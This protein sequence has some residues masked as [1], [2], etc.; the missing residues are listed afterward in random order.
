MV[1]VDKAR[2][3]GDDMRNGAGGN[4]HLP[5]DVV[6]SIEDLWVEYQTPAGQM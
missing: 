4:G 2:R 3:S 5:D 6:L 1:K